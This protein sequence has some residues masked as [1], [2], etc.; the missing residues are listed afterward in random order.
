MALEAVE[1]VAADRELPLDSR[2]EESAFDT[3]YALLVA[4][5]DQPEPEAETH[6]LDDAWFD[7]PEDV[8]ATLPSIE[9]Q[10]R[11]IAAWWAAL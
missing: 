8:L 11:G 6:S 1:K 4:E 5:L 3:A 10:P 9:D 7:V 2:M